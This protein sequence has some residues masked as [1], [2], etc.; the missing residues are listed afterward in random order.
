MLSKYGIS[1]NI[2]FGF[3]SVHD[4]LKNILSARIS[5]VFLS[6]ITLQRRNRALSPTWEGTG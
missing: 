6:D 1:E 4:H 5:A 3:F 2:R